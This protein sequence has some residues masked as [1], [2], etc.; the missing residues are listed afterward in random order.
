MKKDF[1]KS[2]IRWDATYMWHEDVILTLQ[3]RHGSTCGWRAAVW[4]DENTRKSQS[5]VRERISLHTRLVFLLFLSIWDNSIS[6]TLYQPV[7]KIKKKNSRTPAARWPHV[8]TI[9]DVILMLKW[10]HH[11]TCMSHRSKLMILWKPFHAFQIKIRYSW[12]RKGIHYLCE[13]GI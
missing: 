4:V 10:R 12:A 11:V 3:W 5:D 1:W 9:R 8:D 6:H 2:W 7:G 13:D